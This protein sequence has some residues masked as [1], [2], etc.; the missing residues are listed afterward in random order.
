[1]AGRVDD[2]DLVVAPVG[3]GGGGGDGDAPFFFLGH[4][5]HSRG[6]F[7]HAAN[8]ADAS[9]Q[10]EGP[11]GNGGFTGVDVGDESDIADLLGRGLYGSHT[12]T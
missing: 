11:F 5:V 1:M 6:A 4:P 9:G 3:G 7:V 8:L 12:C 10:I 2:V